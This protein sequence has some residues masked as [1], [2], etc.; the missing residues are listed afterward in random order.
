MDVRALETAC[1]WRAEDVADPAVWTELLTPA[2]I[3]EIDEAVSANLDR[4]DDLLSVTKADFPL[5]TLGRR[6]KA[7]EASCG[8]EPGEAARPSHSAGTRRAAP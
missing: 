3:D 2:E 6:L 5:P 1:E 8:R 4:A 7:I